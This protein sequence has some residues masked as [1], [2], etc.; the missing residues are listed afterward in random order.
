[1]WRPTHLT[2]SDVGMADIKF[3]ME[4]FHMVLARLSDDE[5]YR[6]QQ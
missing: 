2:E 4:G 3:S 5:I 1:M 6:L